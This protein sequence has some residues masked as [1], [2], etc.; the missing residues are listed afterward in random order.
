MNKEVKSSPFK[1]VVNGGAWM[2]PLGV[3]VLM[4]SP[5]DYPNVF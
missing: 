4:L 1:D 2:V 5:K 3:Y